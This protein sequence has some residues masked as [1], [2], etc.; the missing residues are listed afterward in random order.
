MS[1]LFSLQIVDISDDA[2]NNS[3]V[4]MFSCESEVG[5]I[6]SEI[7]LERGSSKKG[8]Q[9]NKDNRVRQ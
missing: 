5:V 3:D 9:N 6:V 4:E 2:T 1:H 8:L 7:N